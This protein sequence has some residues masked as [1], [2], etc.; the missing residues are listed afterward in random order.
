MSIMLFSS[1]QSDTSIKY[2]K[3]IISKI[4]FL[5]EVPKKHTKCCCC[6]VV[7]VIRFKDTLLICQISMQISEIFN[8]QFLYL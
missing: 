4:T 1:F 3:Y 5:K 8:L 6:F 2:N 7:A